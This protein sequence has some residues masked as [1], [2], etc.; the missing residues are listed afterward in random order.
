MGIIIE[1]KFGVKPEEEA[2]V[3]MLYCCPECECQELRVYVDGSI[4][5]SEYTEEIEL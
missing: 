5:C 2:P 3:R 1:G 4:E